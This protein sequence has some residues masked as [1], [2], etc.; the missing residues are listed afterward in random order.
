MIGDV[1]W[2]V[3]A[4]WMNKLLSCQPPAVCGGECCHIFD[5]YHN[6]PGTCNYLDTTGCT[7]LGIK[8]PITCLLYPLRLSASNTLVLYIRVVQGAKC[9]GCYGH[10]EPI[11]KALESNLIT[12]FGVRNYIDMRDNV[13]Q[14]TGF[15]FRVPDSVAMRLSQEASLIREH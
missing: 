8:K 14:G 2:K 4:K 12:L 6:K 13:K 9:Q 11:I 15:E 10:G 1:Y 5:F 3:S 7:L